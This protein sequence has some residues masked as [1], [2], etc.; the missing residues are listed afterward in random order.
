MCSDINVS[1]YA[2]LLLLGP[3]E[4]NCG[5]S[6]WPFSRRYIPSVRGIGIIFSFHAPRD[7]LAT[8]IH[9]IDSI[10]K[11]GK[12]ENVKTEEQYQAIAIVSQRA[13]GFHT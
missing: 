11:D 4:V 5:A 2:P 9:E 10:L 3:Q 13:R 12:L 7:L 6:A 8:T 1:R